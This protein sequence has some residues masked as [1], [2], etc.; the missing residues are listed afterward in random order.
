MAS[1]NVD[2]RHLRA[3][4]AVAET[5]NF[6]RAAQRLLIS[7]PSLSY[8]I[9]QLE[10]D[11]GL[12]LFSRTTRSTVLTRE[13]AWFLPEARAILDR[14]D[15]T[16]ATA[17]RMARGEL[18]QLRVGYLI[19][20]AV[21][22]VPDILRAFA[23]RYPAV[24]VEPREYDFGAPN[25]GLDTGETDVA[26]VRPP[27]DLPGALSYPMLTEPCVACVP[28][29]HPIAR[30]ATVSVERLV[31][32]PI[33]AAPG[34]GVWRDYWLLA[35]FRDEPPNVVYEAAT[36]EAELQAV[37]LGRGLSIVPASAAR[38]YARPGVRFVPIPELA[39]CEVAAV[40]TADAP[41]AAARFARLAVEV[42]SGAGRGGG[43]TGAHEQ[44]AERAE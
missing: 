20:A 3:F 21:A 41:P 24:G 36:F 12:R 32:E 4:V 43:A 8:T 1:I 31:S 17:S 11:L 13:G 27:L 22:Q 7:Q 44:R 15:E 25:G 19:G 10:N 9:R 29:R 16:L 6:T 42:A 5:E 28:E 14:L 2:V 40:H 26:I 37:A 34:S 33:V 39:D 35:G 30:D 23:R 18:G 38:F